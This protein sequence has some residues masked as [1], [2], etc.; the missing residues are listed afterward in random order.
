MPRSAVSKKVFRRMMA[1]A[2]MTV[3]DLKSAAPD[4]RLHWPL[5]RRPAAAHVKRPR[6]LRTGAR[7]EPQ[8]ALPRAGRA[9]LDSPRLENRTSTTGDA[10]ASQFSIENLVLPV[11]RGALKSSPIRRG[12]WPTRHFE[13]ALR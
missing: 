3:G 12:H 13:A 8:K 9:R 10:L 11:T 6:F 1:G 4:P 7:R 2:P 5:E